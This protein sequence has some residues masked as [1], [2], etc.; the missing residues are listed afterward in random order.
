MSD[1][2]LASFFKPNGVA[3]IGAS[4]D[5]AKLGYAVLRNLLQH[6]YKGPVYPVNPK[7]DEILGARCYPSILDAPD[8]VELAVIIAPAAATPDILEQVGQRGIHAAI[9]ISGGF[10]EI[11]QPGMEL[12]NR[13]V[14]IAR[15]HAVRLIGP[16]CV[17]RSVRRRH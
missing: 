12:E 10:S 3:L 11:G 17:G 14:E 13:V 5:P 8:P 1:S 7:A 16:N 2:A 15:R 9:I 6:G 4:R